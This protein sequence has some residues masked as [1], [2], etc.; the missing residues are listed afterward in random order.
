MSQQRFTRYL[1]EDGC[2]MGKYLI[3]TDHIDRT[4]G[5]S[6]QVKKNKRLSPRYRVPTQIAFSNSL[7]FPYLISVQPQIFP[8]PIYVICDYYIQKTD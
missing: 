8:A 4:Y 1:G 7:Y 3:N 5:Q 6:N 2:L